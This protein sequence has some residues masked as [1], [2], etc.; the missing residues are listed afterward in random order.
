MSTIDVV[1]AVT[2]LASFAFVWFEVSQ[3]TTR[4]FREYYERHKN[5]VWPAVPGWVFGLVWF[6]IKITIV[7]ALFFYL[8]L[9]AS[10]E[11]SIFTLWV[12]NEVLRK[13]WTFFFMDTRMTG[14]AFFVCLG[15]LGTGLAVL[16]LLALCEHWLSFG[17]LVFY[18]VWVAFACILNL[19]WW[20][21]VPSTRKN[22]EDP[23][24]SAGA[25]LMGGKQQQSSALRA[26]RLK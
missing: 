10:V 23:F 8:R 3:V 25:P 22:A 7:L 19:Q 20:R 13:Y 24:L 1:E 2:F 4:E 26:S 14:M 18:N 17:L 16:V 6:A 21:Q 15:I 11:V 5:K 9:N 12:V